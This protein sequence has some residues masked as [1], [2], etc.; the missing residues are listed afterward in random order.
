GRRPTRSR[1]TRSRSAHRGAGRGPRCRRRGRESGRWCGDGRASRGGPGK[2]P[3]ALAS[4]ARRRCDTLLRGM[5]RRRTGGPGADLRVRAAIADAGR[6]N[7]ATGVSVLDHLV[8]LLAEYAVLDIVLEVE[9]GDAVAE[10]AT[11]GRAL[12]EALAGELHRPDAVGYGAAVV[13]ADEALAHV[14]LE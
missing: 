9:P 6:A 10:V 11:A 4:A 3:L 1:R 14:A 5:A 7:V 8:S 2:E 13:P 12:G